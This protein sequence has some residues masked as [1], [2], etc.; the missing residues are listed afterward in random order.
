MKC[1]KISQDQKF[2]AYLKYLESNFNLAVAQDFV[3]MLLTCLSLPQ[4]IN[5]YRF[6]INIS[7]HQV[8]EVF[9]EPDLSERLEKMNTVFSDFVNKFEIWNKLEEQYDFRA[10]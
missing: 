7:K 3:N 10:D 9:E 4:Y 6:L 1:F 8:Q 5:T 2:I